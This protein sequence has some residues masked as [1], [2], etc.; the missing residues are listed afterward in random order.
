MIARIGKGT[1]LAAVAGAA[2]TGLASGATAQDTSDARW[3]PWLGC[4]VEVGAPTDAPMRCFVPE[5]EG[6]AEMTVGLAGGV[7]R[8]ALVGDGVERSAAIEGCSG[9]RSAEFSADG[10]RVYTRDALTC[11]GGTERS[12]RGMM[13]W[14]APDQWIQARALQVAGRSS[15]WVKRYRAAPE[16]RV[17]AA[18]LEW[19]GDEVETRQLAIEAARIAASAPIGVEDV[20]EAYDRTESEA[21]RSWIVEQ[22][23]P[24][25]LDAER[26]VMLADAGVPE[27]V[28]DVMI[29]VSYPDRFQVAREPTEGAYPGQFR[30]PVYPAWGWSYGWPFYY[31]PFYSGYGYGYYGRYSSWGYGSWYGG[32]Y[33]YPGTIV[34]VRPGE[35]SAGGGRAVN[36]RGYTRGSGGSGATASPASRVRPSR[37]SVGRTG[38][39][40]GSQGAATPRATGSSSSS[41]SKAKAK[42]RGGN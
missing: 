39:S 18:G 13:A 4:W 33:G 5:G 34:I 1:L 38:Y 20:V 16:S 14:V 3:L 37:P 29:A 22:A 30:R 35:E 24:I 27:D 17:S 15:G 31:D 26:L 2:L 19:V 41:G 8:Q 25:E 23:E 11:E 21:V 7:D 36:G 9:V 6:V 28:I 10:T 12:T 42:P 40:G 32:G